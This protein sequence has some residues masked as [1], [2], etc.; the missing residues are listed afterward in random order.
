MFETMRYNLIID[1]SLYNSP[2]GFVFLLA[3][4]GKIGGI[5]VAELVSVIITT[6]KRSPDIV[7]RAVQSVLSQTYSDLELII[8]DDSPE[9]FEGREA[10]KTTLLE[11]KDTRIN[12]IQ[13]LA[14]KGACAA[15]NSGINHATGKYIAFL[16]DDDV[17]YPHKLETQLNKMSEVNC[18]L[19]YC[20]SITINE[21]T[22]TE[23]ERAD[24][25]FRG[26]VF[27]ELLRTNFI[28]ST[29]FPL[30]KAKCFAKCGSF[31]ESLES[32]QDLDMWLRIAKKYKVDYIDEPLVNYYVHK[33]EAISR[34][35]YKK[36]KGKLAINEKYKDHLNAQPKIL[37]A[38]LLTMIP[39]Y[40]MIGE[41][42][43][44]FSVYFSAFKIA[45]YEI[46]INLKELIRIIF[47]YKVEKVGKH[48]AN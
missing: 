4:M 48:N 25:F 27:D 20:R 40:L 28:G 22:N 30:I 17:W 1:V 12:Y 6:Y 21:I 19:V 8:I 9:S 16:D 39:F 36:I 31:D 46:K 2:I 14:N 38:R 44:A 37:R 11:I 13:H 29:S 35:P 47:N 3:K 26:D 45:P 24:K 15:R 23:K 43:K 18:G 5:K 42:K 10:V 32:S 33:G 34:N 7:L 41:K